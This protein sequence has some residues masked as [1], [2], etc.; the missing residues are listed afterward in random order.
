ML[1]MLVFLEINGV[2]ISPEVNEV[3][4]VGLDVASGK[5]KYDELLEWIL[6]NK[7]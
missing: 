3:S 2:K 7:E 4:R 1:V 5:M 6:E